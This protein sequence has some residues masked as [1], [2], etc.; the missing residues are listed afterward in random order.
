MHPM[1]NA[2]YAEVPAAPAAGEV[3]QCKVKVGPGNCR[4][5]FHGGLS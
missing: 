3:S 5:R 2:R 1:V 4:G